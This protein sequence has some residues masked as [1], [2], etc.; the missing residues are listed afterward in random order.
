MV[1]KDRLSSIHVELFWFVFYTKP[2]SERKIQEELAAKHIEAYLPVTKTL[3]VWKNRQKK[4]IHQVLFPN[5]IFVK[6]SHSQ[7]YL[8]KQTHNV[9]KNLTCSGKPS[10]ITSGEIERI[11]EILNTGKDI[12]VETNLIK[13]KRVKI[14][15]GPFM[16]YDGVLI[17]QK[18]K[19]RFGIQ[20][21]A[22]NH[23][24]LVDIEITPQSFC[25]Y[26]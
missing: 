8:I 5:Y 1:K 4:W 21:E 7:L 25:S 3:R 22:I 18:G 17:E 15:T 12:D 2:N 10:I 14:L 23:T 9:I 6:A 26:D 24:I 19:T 11:K 20:I 16:G 13:G